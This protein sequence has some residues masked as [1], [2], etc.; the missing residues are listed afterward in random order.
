MPPERRDRRAA[1]VAGAVGLSFL[2]TAAALG[3]WSVLDYRRLETS[4]APHCF[5]A[6]SDAI[7]T[8]ALVADVALGAAVVSAGVA[9]VLWLTAPSGDGSLRSARSRA[10]GFGE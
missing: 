10:V 7:H 9:I 2:T 4:C 1:Y 3:A 5:P 8:R 6:E